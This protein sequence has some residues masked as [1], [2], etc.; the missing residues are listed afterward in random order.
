M[1]HNY[2]VTVIVILNS[3]PLYY[4]SNFNTSHATGEIVLAGDNRIRLETKKTHNSH[5]FPIILLFVYNKLPQ[6]LDYSLPL[7]RNQK[8]KDFWDH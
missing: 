7:S 5:L 2:S 4:N 1:F 3:N 8:Q 6:S